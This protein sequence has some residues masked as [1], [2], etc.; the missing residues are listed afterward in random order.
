MKNEGNLWFVVKDTVTGLFYAG[1]GKWTSYESAIRCTKGKARS[2]IG[3]LRNG[4]KNPMIA[5]P[6]RSE[7]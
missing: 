6:A 2:M 1:K 7:V 5:V 3:G 4:N